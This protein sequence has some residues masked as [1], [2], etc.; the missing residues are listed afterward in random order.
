[1][2]TSNT[3]SLEIGEGLAVRVE[4][5]DV[6]AAVRGVV[7]VVGVQWMLLRVGRD[8]A[9]DGVGRLLRISARVVL[10][11]FASKRVCEK[12]CRWASAESSVS[13]LVEDGIIS[14]RCE[15]CCGRLGFKVAFSLEHAKAVWCPELVVELPITSASYNTR[16]SSS[17]KP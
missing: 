4:D 14:G 15:V 16:Q 10:S 12:A 8:D 1:M 6:D 7:G 17:C 11:P 9:C 3:R 13:D 5:V 2:K